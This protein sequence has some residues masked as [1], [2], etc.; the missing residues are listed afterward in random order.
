[1][2]K[3][4]VKYLLKYKVL[5]SKY[6]GVSVLLIALL[7]IFSACKKEE[8]EYVHGK[9]NAELVP[10]IDT[11]SVTMN[12]SD[13]GRVKYKVITKRMQIFDKAKDPHW[14]F[15]HGL[16]LEQYDNLFKVNATITADTVWNFTAKGIWQLRGHVVIKNVNGSI[17]KTPELFWDQRQQKIYTDKFISIVT[18]EKTLKGYGLDASQDLKKYK[19]RKPTGF[20]MMGKDALQ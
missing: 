9:Y 8:R 5:P 15:P 16:Y 13:S 1:M 6:Y 20:M 7:L 10:S 19:I 14:F 3:M 17:F 12:I 4:L 18:P 11:D 2:N